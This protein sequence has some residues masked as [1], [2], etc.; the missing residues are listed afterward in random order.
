[1]TI[2]KFVFKEHNGKRVR[3]DPTNHY[4][5][6]TD[7]CKAS[8]KEVKRFLAQE[9]VRDFT[10]ELS[11]WVQIPSEKLLIVGKGSLGT[12]AH[13][14]I[15]Y[16][17]AAWCS[18]ILDI[19][20]HTWIDELLTTGK[21]ELAPQPEPKALLFEDDGD[22]ASNMAMAIAH[23]LLDTTNDLE[24]RLKVPHWQ[25]VTEMLG[26]LG[27][28]R[29]EGSISIDG[30]FRHWVNKDFCGLYR[31]RNGILPPQT[32]TKR[33]GAYCYPPAYIS[34]LETYLS[35]YA[36]NSPNKLISSKH[37]QLS[38]LNSIAA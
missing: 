24:A 38:L 30:S 7:L 29:E 36:V 3:I 27:Y 14:Y 22:L 21:V 8:G 32:E 17:C 16:K 33:G 35:G 25:T 12:W 9:N 2:Q 18:P 4:P 11:S 26:S 34:L 37:I 20:M 23:R 5:C 13:R 31:S 15:G 28:V 6:L 1:M 10:S 19:L